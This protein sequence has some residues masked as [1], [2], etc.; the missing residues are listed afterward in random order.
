LKQKADKGIEKI[1][2]EEQALARIFCEWLDEI[3]QRRKKGKWQ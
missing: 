2:S 3:N 1:E